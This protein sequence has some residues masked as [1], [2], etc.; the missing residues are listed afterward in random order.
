[1]NFEHLNRWLT[2]FANIGIVIGLIMVAVQIQ[3]ESDLA[4]A[5]L[6]SDHTDSRRDWNQAMMGESPMEIVAKSIENPTEL[7][8]AESHV[9]DFY[10][11]GAVNELRRLEMLANSGLDIGVDIEGFHHFFFGSPFAQAW[12]EEFRADEIVLSDFEDEKIRAVDD[13]WIE[14]FFNRVAAR[15]SAAD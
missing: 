14:G 4:R 7:T 15:L 1:M 9:M 2:L 12:Y 13:Q 8:L 6:F 5:Q 11:V 3:Q 10:L